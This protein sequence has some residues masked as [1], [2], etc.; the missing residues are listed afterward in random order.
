MNIAGLREVVH[1][2]KQSVVSSYKRDSYSAIFDLV[3]NSTM[4]E[5]FQR[6]NMRVL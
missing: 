2:R 5:N 1:Q 3:L 6:T 4:I